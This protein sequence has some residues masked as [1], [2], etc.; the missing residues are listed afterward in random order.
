MTR[1][2]WILIQALKNLKNLVFYW[3]LLCKLFHVWPTNGVTFH[4]TEEQCKIWRKN[5]LWFEKWHEESSKLFHQSTRNSQ[6]W[7]FDGI[8]LFKVEN[9]YELKIYKGVV[10]HDNEKWCKIWRGI[11]LSFQ[12]WHEQFDK[13]WPNDSK[14]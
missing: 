6:N 14:M 4:D 3:F 5:D 11:D 8:L 9:V 12:S 10:C 1:T 2:W 7:D 13:C